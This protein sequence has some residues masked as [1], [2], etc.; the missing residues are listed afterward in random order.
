MNALV[1]FGSQTRSV[2]SSKLF[3]LLFV[4]I[5]SAMS[6]TAA[7]STRTQ[8]PGYHKTF[9]PDFRYKPK[10]SKTHVVLRS[11]EGTRFFF[12]LQ[13]LI[14]TSA[15]FADSSPPSP[16][17]DRGLR[18]TTAILHYLLSFVRLKFDVWRK[19]SLPKARSPLDGALAALRIARVLDVPNAAGSSHKRI[20]LDAYLLAALKHAVKGTMPR[21]KPILAITPGD[22]IG[23]SSLKPN[24]W[25]PE[26][27][28]TPCSK[29]IPS[30][31]EPLSRFNLAQRH[32]IAVVERWFNTGKSP[33]H[34]FHPYY[35][36]IIQHDSDCRFSH[37]SDA[38]FAHRL[39]IIAPRAL[40]I[41]ANAYSRLD[42][43]RMIRNLI[44]QE[45]DRCPGC[46]LQL[47]GVYEPAIYNFDVR[48]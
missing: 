20:D 12:P 38:D 4:R 13:I 18:P 10:Y 3:N 40:D 27:S 9:H 14:D 21:P 1:V 44:A 23:S 47:E 28:L 11:G 41:L 37:D 26:G 35:P 29:P 42:R 33:S 32:E 24:F 43:S 2:M 16:A 5:R 7:L 8:E 17:Y 48:F 19:H 25:Q 34:I 45:A 31:F 15:V 36:L 39:S 30:P 22:R 6:T 46:V